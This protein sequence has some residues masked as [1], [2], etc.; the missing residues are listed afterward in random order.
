VVQAGVEVDVGA[1]CPEGTAKLFAADQLAR[2][3]REGGEHAR[4][5]VRE[6][7]RDIP[8]PDLAGLWIEA[9]PAERSNLFHGSS[10][11]SFPLAYE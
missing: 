3:A 2:A 8:S 5:L 6:T 11:P 7:D 4:G 1:A 9:E 10:P